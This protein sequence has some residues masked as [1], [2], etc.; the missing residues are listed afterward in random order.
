MKG[1]G[2][3]LGIAI[4]CVVLVIIAVAGIGIFFVKKR[5]NNQKTK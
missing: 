2:L 1:I 3:I 4:P 5:R